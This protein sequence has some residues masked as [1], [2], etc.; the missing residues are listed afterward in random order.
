MTDAV[1][2]ASGRD[3]DVFAIDTR[4]V[5]RRYRDGSDATAEAKTMAYVAALGFPVP[6]VHSATGADVV[7]ERLHGPTMLEALV[8][9]SMDVDE[10]AALLTDLHGRL[11]NL[12][13]SLSPDPSA[14]ILHLDLHPGNVMICPHGPVVID[15]RNTTE[16]P[17]ELD[18]AMSA[19]ILAEVAVDPGADL[20]VAAAA[21]L[22]A[23]LRHTGDG[24][25]RMLDRA[26]AMRR[27]DPN[28]TAEEV[29]RLTSAAALINSGRER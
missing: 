1:P 14:R 20:A 7:M 24:P 4:T 26:V 29:S 21:M 12:P 17:A 3:A 11:H 6:K 16:G 25:P 28:L 2:I 19:L 18:L 13:A 27:R 22:D 9:G 23:F 15:W 10:G 5:L 8:A